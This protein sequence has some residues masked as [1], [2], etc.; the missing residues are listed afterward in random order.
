[1]SG[2]VSEIET[3]WISRIM[4]RNLYMTRVKVDDLIQKIQIP[5]KSQNK[6]SLITIE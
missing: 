6:T 4:W 5:L 3:I 1:M 2:L